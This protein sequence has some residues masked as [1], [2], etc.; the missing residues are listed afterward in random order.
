MPKMPDETTVIA[1][2]AAKVRMIEAAALRSLRL[3][4]LRGGP[5]SPLLE[6]NPISLVH[7]LRQ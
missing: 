5:A 2:S 4:V 6:Q 3:A 7:I 1:S